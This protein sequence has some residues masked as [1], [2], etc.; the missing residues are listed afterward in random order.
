MFIDERGLIVRSGRGGDGKVAWR[1]EKRVPR[2]GPAGG[3][4][5]DGGS[6]IIWAD[7][8]LT[9]FADMEDV[10]T[11]RAEDGVRGGS[12]DRT[13]A[14]GADCVLGVPIGTTAYDE[15]SGL[16][17]ADLATADRRWVA[18]RGGKGGRGNGKFATA[19]H[20]R[21]TEAESG[22]DGCERR[23]RLELRVL[24]DVGLV[25]L[26]NA[27]KS[28]LLSRLSAA[29]PRIADYPFTTLEPHLGLVQRP[30]GGRYVMADLP[31]L[32]EG[33]HRGQGLGDR[34]LRHLERTRV[35]LHLVD[36]APIDGTDPVVA[37]RRIRTELEAYGRALAGRPE[38]VVG[39]KI[40]AISNE[41]LT[42]TLRRLA[43]EVDRDVHPISAVTGAGL[44][45]LLG[46]V[47]A[48]LEV[49]PPAPEVPER[50][51]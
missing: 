24:A 43:A 14:R 9:T 32:I 33:A 44:G 29:R 27:G 3:D 16:K 12:G 22:G 6:V 42:P 10:R 47:D 1:R 48:A 45:D 49:A 34:F 31:G 2:G 5:G 36:L 4:G 11:A 7:P 50:R 30:E 37:Y 18:A 39:T 17:L 23:L 41:S 46:A 26:P 20:Q 19:T 51:P 38:I 40:D 21:P 25:G 15:Q 13:G 35:L 8:Q 28:T